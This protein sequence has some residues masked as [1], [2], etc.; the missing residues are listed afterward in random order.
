MPSMMA[1]PSLMTMPDEIQQALHMCKIIDDINQAMQNRISKLERSRGQI[2]KD[3]QD[4]LKDVQ[5]WR[6]Q[7]TLKAD[8]KA[9]ALPAFVS[10]HSPIVE[11]SPVS[12]ENSSSQPP[13]GLQLAPIKDTNEYR[14]TWRLEKSKFRE[15]VNRPLVSQHITIQGKEL[16]LMISL[17][18]ESEIDGQSARDVKATMEKL[19]RDGPLTGSVKLKAVADN[20]GKLLMKFKLF[21]G[22][23]VQDI[24]EHDFGDRVTFESKFESDWLKEFIDGTLVI[25][26]DILSITESP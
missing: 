11:T 20:G 2:N 17:G 23:I 24:V 25:G 6:K 8:T 19:V 1:M 12:S 14:L 22:S 7:D 9:E 21:V 16:K 26:C 13:L 15:C 5:E 4:M 18:N 10:A 3:V